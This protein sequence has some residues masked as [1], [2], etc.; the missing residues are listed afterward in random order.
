MSPR[1]KLAIGLCFIATLGAC[2]PSTREPAPAGSPTSTILP[3]PTPSVTSTATLTPA[4]PPSV[5]PPPSPTVAPTSCRGHYTWAYG[6]VS[7]EFI[8][9]VRDAMAAARIE[10]TV[11]AS[12]FGENNG[13]CGYGP[14]AVDYIFTVQVAGLEPSA[15][16]ANVAAR[17]LEIATRL[18][19]AS[20]AP[21]LGHLQLIF[22]AG[23]QQCQWGYGDGAWNSVPSYTSNAVTCPVPTSP[24]SQRL[25]DTL[26][27]LSGDLACGTSTVTGNPLQAVLECERHEGHNRLLITVKFRLNGQGSERIC[28]HG[29]QAFESSMTGDTPM[30]VIEHG[31]GHVTSYFERDRTFEWTANGILFALS[32]RIEGGPDVTLPPDTREK[33]FARVVQAGLIPGEGNS[34]L[35]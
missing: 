12:T 13:A 26:T 31:V 20:P 9:Q 34:C 6:T 3:S 28:F 14:M 29:Y 16:L 18:V 32:E 11:Q 23:D 22:Q 5:A 2:G 15:E 17:I 1:L 25:A 7:S 27:A 33:V 10:G 4:V 21:Y 35:E 19:H 8:N 24:E 30:T